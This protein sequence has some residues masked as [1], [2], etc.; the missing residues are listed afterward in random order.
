MYTENK[1]SLV[2][3]T[4]GRSKEVGA[5]LESIANI[6]YNKEKIQIIIVDQ[7]DKINLDEIIKPYVSKLDITHIRSDKKGLS[8]N[9]NIGLKN[10]TGDIIAFPDDDCE[11]ME[12]TLEIINNYFNEN[13]HNI[14]MGRIIERDGSDSL[15]A[16]PK[17]FM[18]I[19]KSNFYTKCSSVTMFLKLKNC[20]VKFNNNLGAGT[21]FGACEDADLIYKNIKSVGK[22]KYN[23]DVKIYHPHYDSNH[24]MAEAK[25]YSYA[26][27]F[28]AMVRDNLDFSMI[29][30]FIK[31]EG[32]HFLKIIYGLLKFNG[33]L[34]KKSYLAFMGRI[35]GFIRFNGSDGQ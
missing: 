4:Y 7:N 11:Y 3:A 14:L 31:A 21:K 8:L 19:D 24:N 20:K 27:G 15:R 6:H 34:A 12:D 1:F 33:Q 29:V 25:V 10:V 13:N 32:Y 22:V 9:R 18:D 30:L 28:G 17:K 5:F 35:K 2:M 16:W 23:P 26:L